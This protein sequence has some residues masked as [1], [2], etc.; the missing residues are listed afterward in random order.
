M[1]FSSFFASLLVALEFP[2]SLSVIASGPD[3]IFFWVGYLMSGVCDEGIKKPYTT[4]LQWG[5]KK[6][7][8]LQ[9][10]TSW[11]LFFK[12]FGTQNQSC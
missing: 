11:I 5:R 7:K 1:L 2:T 12:F 4:F 9:K 6:L 8:S 3:T 10:E